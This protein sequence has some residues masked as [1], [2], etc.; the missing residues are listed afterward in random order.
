MTKDLTPYEV[1]ERIEFWK[2]TTMNG[3]Y[4]IERTCRAQKADGTD[5]YITCEIVTD[6]SVAYTIVRDHPEYQ[7]YISI[8]QC[9]ILTTYSNLISV[10]ITDHALLPATRSPRLESLR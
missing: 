2:Q 4:V 6:H 3:E 7:I 10:Q 5:S 8:P 1:D 9:V